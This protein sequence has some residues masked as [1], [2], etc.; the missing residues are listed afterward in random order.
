MDALQSYTAFVRS[1]EAGSFSAVAR[2][3]GTSQ[4]AV[5]KQIAALENSLGVQLFARTTRRLQ[6][7]SEALQLYEH[8]RQLLDAMDALRSASGRKAV[9]SGTLRITLPSSYAKRRI[10]PL[11]PGFLERFPQVSLD[12]QLT[13][14]VLDLVEE[15]L[16]LGVRIG[17]LAPSTLMARPIGVVDQILVASP[18]YLSKQGTPDT[19]LDLSNHACVLYG[20]G[21]RWT[22]WEFESESGRHAVEVSGPV[23]VNDPQAMFELVCA[24]QGI[25]LVPDWVIAD[26]ITSGR[27]T[28]LMPEFYPIPQPVNFVYPQTRFLS[29]RARSFIDYILE[30]HRQRR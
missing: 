22:R 21:T 2:E 30:T 27:V 4:S 10:I 23:R 29:Q 28:W 12:I 20:G 1:F 8:V 13:D 19:P 5:S 11:L 6:P 16:E 25:A 17:N 9:A 18:E 3:M 15:G 14:Q 26:E 24:H 7:T